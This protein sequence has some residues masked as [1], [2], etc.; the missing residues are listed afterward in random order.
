[1][2]TTLLKLALVPLAVWLASFAGRRWGHGV[3][4]WVSGLPV[5]AA[6]I[7]IFVTIAEGNDF[8]AA[9]ALAILQCTPANAAYYV[10]YAYVSRRHGW[11]TALA[12]GWAAFL[13]L[14]ALL[15]AIA[16]PLPLAFALNLA[17]IYACLRALP[18]APRLS[19]PAPIPNTELGV[20]MAAAFAL[21]AILAYGATVFGPRISGILL[22]F[23]I[24]GSVLPAFTRAL[25][26]WNAAVGLL[27]GFLKGLI[28]F[29]TFF[30]V[31]AAVLASRG[32]VVGFVAATIAA[33]V[34]AWL[35]GRLAATR[36]PR[37][38]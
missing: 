3:A 5:I 24:S 17:V 16:P 32:A 12:A 19:G 14:S 38:R 37:A 35:L 4:G 25:H 23:P 2:L 22:T 13:V 30:A 9:A 27:G 1:M 34:A 7:M 29:A 18:A 20:R 31:L 28:G 21:A 11:A 36:P 15:V 10:V 8:G 33:I 26:G 6:P